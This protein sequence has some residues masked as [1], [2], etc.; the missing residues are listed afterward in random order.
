M[1]RTRP[2]HA[3]HAQKRITLGRANE[4]ENPH[5]A[6]GSREPAA[7]DAP[8]S[9]GFGI[10][11]SGTKF[12]SLFCAVGSPQTELT[13]AALKELLSAALGRLGDRNRVLAVPPDQTRIH[14]RAGEL[15][16]YAWSHYRSEEAT[17]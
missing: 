6:R 14:S 3:R 10:K 2:A 17:V 5:P 11:E 7:S 4:C 12:M 9:A 16:R 13:A 1:G 15:T 8:A